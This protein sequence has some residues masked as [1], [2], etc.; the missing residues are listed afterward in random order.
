MDEHDLTVWCEKFLSTKKKTV[1]A[2]KTRNNYEWIKTHYPNI[3]KELENK[4]IYIKGKQFTFSERKDNTLIINGIQY[5]NKNRR[6]H[7]KFINLVSEFIKQN[8]NY[9]F[10]EIIK[11]ILSL[12]KSGIR[13][14][15]FIEK[16]YPNKYKEMIKY[17]DECENEREIV[18]RFMNNIRSEERRVGKECRSRW[19]PY[20]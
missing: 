1:S 5:C 6:I 12:G 15:K 3:W 8:P 16:C 2:N 13:V 9:T 14:M 19:S 17:S 7:M 10:D 20:H 4:T 18:Y 11:Y